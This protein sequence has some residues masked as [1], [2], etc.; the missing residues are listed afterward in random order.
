MNP[1]IEFGQFIVM[2]LWLKRRP[3][4]F[5]STTLCQEGIQHTQSVAEEA[6]LCEPSG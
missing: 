2:E 1:P 4:N 5:P 6:K 3:N